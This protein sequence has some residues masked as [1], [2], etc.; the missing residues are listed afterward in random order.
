MTSGTLALFALLQTDPMPQWEYRDA[1]ATL[2][3]AVKN[4]DS[5]AAQESAQA[6]IGTTYVTS[7]GEI[8]STDTTCLKPVATADPLKFPARVPCVETL[9]QSLDEM[10]K[11]VDSADAPDRKLAEEITAAWDQKIPEGIAK[12]RVDANLPAIEASILPDW[13]VEFWTWLVDAVDAILRAL[14]GRSASGGSSVGAEGITVVIV[15][16]ACALL[17]LVAWRALRQARLPKQEEKPVEVAPTDDD[18]TARPTSEWYRHAEALMRAGKRREALRAYYHAVLS[19][20][21][22]IGLLTYSRGRTNWEYVASLSPGLP[23]R[24]RLVNMTRRFEECWYGGAEASEDLLLAQSKDAT[25][26]L[27]DLQVSRS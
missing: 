21:I 15:A 25:Q 9:V 22:Q 17:G 20:G 18:P 14:T 23:V 12:F 6:L 2:S 10:T 26:A 3:T 4:G 13:L 5:A 16:L 7:D 19:A 1:L 8:L 27:A 11:R 24:T